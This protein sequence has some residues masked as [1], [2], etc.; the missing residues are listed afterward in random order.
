MLPRARLAA[1]A[2][3]LALPMPAIGQ[4]T[5]PASPGTAKEVVIGT[6]IGVA[7]SLASLYFLNAPEHHL[8][9]CV[10]KGPVNLQLQEFKQNAVNIYALEGATAALRPG[11]LVQLSGYRGPRVKRGEIRIFKVSNIKKRYGACPGS[12]PAPPAATP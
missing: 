12:P 6:G 2:L 5:P 4:A 8:K 9:G 3:G 7:F 11:E 1:L 10:I